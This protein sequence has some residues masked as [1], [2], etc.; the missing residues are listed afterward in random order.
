MKTIK[1]QAMKCFSCGTPLNPPEGAQ[2]VVCENCGEIFDIRGF[3]SMELEQEEF[4]RLF[5]YTL[6]KKRII[7][8]KAAN[9]K[10]PESYL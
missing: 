4:D 1:L 8:N 7:T 6:K 9:G 3:S 10:L 5:L 2:N